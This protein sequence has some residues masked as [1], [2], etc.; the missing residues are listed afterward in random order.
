MIAAIS[1]GTASATSS[2]RAT[3]HIVA[4]VL[5]GLMMVVFVA[6]TAH[7]TA[8]RRQHM[9]SFWR[10]CGPLLL[11]C[12]AAVLIMLDPIRHIIMDNT[13]GIIGGQDFAWLLR[14]YRGDCDAESPKCFALGGW[15]FTYGTT[16][17]GF[18]CLAIS[19]FWL[20]DIVAK[21]RQ[22]RAK[23]RQIRAGRSR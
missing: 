15:M 8:K 13:G 19:T 20:V 6:Y 22:I 2:Q 5:T 14:E 18:L 17:I 4:V 16:W 23:W 12:A 10:R 1:G 3:G 9:P 7:A 21:G 11:A